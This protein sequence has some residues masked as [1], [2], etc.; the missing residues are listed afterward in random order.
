MKITRGDEEEEG[1]EE[2]EEEVDRGE[3]GEEVA[4]EMGDWR[5]VGRGKLGLLSLEGE[6]FGG[7]K[8]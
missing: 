3:K 8:D 2:E 5:E 6:K 7:L 1:G 4:E